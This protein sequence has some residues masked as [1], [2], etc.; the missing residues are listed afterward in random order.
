M[1]ALDFQD[2]AY[3]FEEFIR[4]PAPF[5]VIKDRHLKDKVHKFIF[6]TLISL[7]L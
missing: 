5:K 4:A 3:M 7:V 1:D 2:K 6:S